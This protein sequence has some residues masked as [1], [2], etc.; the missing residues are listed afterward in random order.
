MK[1]EGSS[2]SSPRTLPDSFPDIVYL[3]WARLHRPRAN[4]IQTLH[5]VDSLVQEGLRVRL[6][7]PPWSRRVSLPVLLRDSGVSEQLDVR[8]SLLLHRRWGGVPFIRWHRGM[9][10]A[11]RAVYTRIPALS[12]ALARAGLVNHLEIHDVDWLASAGMLDA[13]VIAHQKGLIRQLLPISGAAYDALLQH[14]AVANRMH[15]APSGVDVDAYA[16]VPEFNPASLARPRLVY[17]GR[18]S[19]DR[20]LGIF[21]A[22]AATGRYEVSLVGPQDD[23]PAAGL[24]VRAP[25]PHSQVPG[26]YGETDIALMPYQSDL[27]HVASISPIKLFEAMAAGRPVL[28]SDLPP[29]RE[30][31]RHGEN[32]LLVSA[33]DP[34]AWIDAIERL[35]ADPA[36][37]QR[38]AAQGRADANRYSWR[39]R[40]RGIVTALGL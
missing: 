22:L 33:A 2:E 35:R 20:G 8:G 24:H 29:L 17:I 13:V 30:V 14:G 9:L 3:A 28:A 37:A 6:Y 10:G 5:T 36:L 25:V 15:L 11:A 16:Q 38:L 4:L 32:G 19:R 31:I 12:L 27:G 26:L 18:I 21:E 40:A 39:A 23:A 34:Q 1:P 7:L